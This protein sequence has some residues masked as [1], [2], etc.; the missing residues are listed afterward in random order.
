VEVGQC[1]DFER[2]I[3]DCK[4]AISFICVKVIAALRECWWE[5]FAARVELA[6][7]IG[8]VEEDVILTRGV[9]VLAS[10]VIDDSK[11]LDLGDLL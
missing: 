1:D 2:S 5:K 11:G 6:E 3:E 7:A 10:V 4:L 8:R 9:D